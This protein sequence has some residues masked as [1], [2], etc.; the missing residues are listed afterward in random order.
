MILTYIYKSKQLES[1]FIEVNNP[2]QNNNIVGVIYRHPCMDEGTFTDVYL[3]QIT[4]K[5]SIENKKIF[6][7]GDFNYDLLNIS[8]HNETFNFFDTMMS[9]FLLPLITIPTKINTINNTLI[10]N[11]FSNHLHPDIRSG[12]LTVG[13]S[14]HLPS[15]MIVPNPNQNHLPKKHNIYIYTLVKQK[16]L[17]MRTSY[18]TTLTLT[19]MKL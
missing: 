4:N 1:F 12:N 19:G 14:D 17:I 11:I 5:L 15:F 6:I 10:D 16:I 13:L 8:S 18:S 9:N 3:K 7:A 2:K